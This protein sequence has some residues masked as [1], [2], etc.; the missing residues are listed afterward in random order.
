MAGEDALIGDRQIVLQ[1]DPAAPNASPF[2]LSER[3]RDL[4]L[5]EIIQARVARAPTAIAV[6]FE[7]ATLTYRELNARA[8]QLAR[9]LRSHGV[10]VGS[11]V[12]I[13]MKRCLEM[14]VGLLAILKAGGAYVPLDPRLPQE[15]L[16]FL[17]SDAPLRVI[18]TRG[19][20]LDVDA[21]QSIDMAEEQYDSEDNRDMDSGV[22]NDDLV[23]VIY[24]SGSTGQPKGVMVPHRGVV[25]WLVW[26]RNTF[27][28]TPA[29]V[30]LKKAPLTFDVSAWELFLPLI[31]G[32]R[33]VLADSDR[34]YDPSYLADLMA[35]Q[36]VTIA[37]FVPSLLQLFL[38]L[39]NLPDLSSLRHV[40]C[41]GEIFTPK[42]QARFF[43]RLTSEVC[44]SYGPTEASIGV[45]RWPCRRDDHRDTVPIGG[46]IDN[47]DLYVLDPDLAPVPPSVAGELYIAGRCLGRG[48]LNRPDL[49]AERF[50]PNP[51]NSDGEAR[52]Y[53]T[54]DLCRFLEDGSIDF[55]GRIDDQVKIRGVR[56]ELAEVEHAIAQHESVKAVGA[57]AEDQ[58]G[59]AALFAY[60]VPAEGSA[61]TDRELR[62][63]L[64]KKLPLSMIPSEFLFVEALPLSANGKIDRK[65]LRSLRP[66]APAVVRPR[67]EIEQRLAEIWRQ[68]LKNDTFGVQ[69]N[70]FDCGGDSLLAT[71]LTIRIEQ[72]FK[73]RVTLDKL[74]DAFTI[75]AIANLVRGRSLTVAGAE[76]EAPPGSLAAA[77]S[78]AIAP[79]AP[80]A[81]RRARSIECRFAD[82]DDIEGIWKVCSL[83]FAP[84]ADSSLEEF[85]ELCLHRWLNNPCR[86]DDDPFGWVSETE[87]G[88][89]VGFHGLVPARLW[90]DGR[91]YSAV[92]P[93][94]WA[95]EPGHGGA[96]LTLLSAYMNWGKD[97]FLL[98]TTANAITSSMHQSSDFGMRQ[99]PI[100]DF[101]ERLLWILNY[102]TLLEWKARQSDAPAILRRVTRSSILRTAVCGLAPFVL[103]IAGGTS[104]ALHSAFG[105]SRIEFECQRL[106]VE[107][108]HQFGSEFDELWDRLKH[109]YAVTVERRAAFLNWRHIN[110][111][112]LLGRSHAL[113]CRENG[114]ILGYVA[115]REPATT[116]P[117]H[118]IVTDLFYDRSRPEVLYNLMNGA[119]DFAIARSASVVEVF[120]FHPE[121]NRALHTQH[122]YVLR[123]TQIERLGRGVSLATMTAALGPRSR[124]VASSTYWYR[125]PT[126]ELARICAT[127]P[128]WPSGIDGDLNL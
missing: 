45:T 101:D 7:G 20:Q 59:A 93:T 121:I 1:E 51:F 89:I 60:V 112:R 113:S 75:E 43:E 12:G 52:M 71:Q 58:G 65:R 8:N 108:I 44:N 79:V 84:Y 27:E 87:S 80:V 62:N 81:P 100:D 88:H 48:Y 30:V 115:L 29:D 56:I 111:P 110:P 35:S 5:H 32:A 76:P 49:T 46:P 123:R 77:I 37:Q 94:T 11:L 119:F 53:R 68:L 73:S 61:L 3:D 83:A 98:N 24:T 15:R 124:S 86:T 99:I 116:A 67:D 2:G 6:Y 107:P 63:F 33:L 9:R 106:Q 54:G 82:I 85:R 104:A 4:C 91:S 42:L 125:A 16:Q 69:D 114:Q 66:A 103:G 92:A 105:R 40:M 95:V 128:W 25:N 118:F 21:T 34:Q 26:M 14:I 78:P 102:R 22:Q 17:V 64:R 122:P 72:T 57:A 39:E 126:A 18:L 38:D 96:G 23:Y 10:G 90:I 47:T 36:H 50:L 19:T 109:G 117:G 120:G 97:R 70:F 127:R 74:L 55:L 41:G 31:T 28:A 13:S